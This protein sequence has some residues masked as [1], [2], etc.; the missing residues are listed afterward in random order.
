MTV[1]KSLARTVVDSFSSNSKELIN[2]G[3]LPSTIGRCT[4]VGRSSGNSGL[5]LATQNDSFQRPG[6]TNIQRS[7]IYAVFDFFYL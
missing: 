5:N 6:N 2:I 3:D 4:L 1:R 7:Y